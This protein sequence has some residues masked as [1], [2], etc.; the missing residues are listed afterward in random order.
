MWLRLN[1]GVLHGV[2]LQELFRLR[3]CHLP[4]LLH[5]AFLACVLLVRRRWP[6]RTLANPAYVLQHALE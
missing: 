2:R 3:R 4:R 1:R 6:V 5:V